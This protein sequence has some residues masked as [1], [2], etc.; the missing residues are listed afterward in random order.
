MR[1]GSRAAKIRCSRVF[2]RGARRKRHMIQRG[3]N[4]AWSDRSG[5][6]GRMLSILIDGEFAPKLAAMFET[7]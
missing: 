7:R 1:G 4:H 2:V 3:T 6:P 5:K